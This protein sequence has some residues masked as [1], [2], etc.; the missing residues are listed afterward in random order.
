VRAPR[1]KA[2]KAQEPR[3]TRR[4]EDIIGSGPRGTRQERWPFKPQTVL[5]RLQGLRGGEWILALARHMLFFR[6]PSGTR[7]RIRTSAVAV[8]NAENDQTMDCRPRGVIILPEALPYERLVSVK[9][10]GTS[11][12][13][14]CGAQ[15]PADADFC[16]V[17][18]LRGALDVGNETVELNVAS[19]LSLPALRF[20]HYEIVT[21]ADGTPLELG[22]GAMGVTYKA[23]D[24]NLQCAVAL[25][26][27]NA[28]FIGDESARRRFVREARAAASVRHPNVASVFHLG[29]SADGYFYAMEFVEGE[30]LENVIKRTVQLELKLALEI[31][32]QVARGLAAVHKAK[33]VHRDIKPSNIM[34]SLDEGGS[35]TAKI[36]DL[37]LAKVVGEA[38]PESAI[39]ASGAFAGTPEFA[40]P[41]Q[42]AGVGVDIRSDL[43][44]LGVVIW[45]M[46]TGR[47]PFRGTPAELI[48]QHQH[49]VLPLK[50]LKGVP[51]QVTTVLKALLDKDPKRRFQTPAELLK[52][53]SMVG[54]ELVKAADQNH[55]VQEPL[56]QKSRVIAEQPRPGPV[57]GE[58]LIDVSSN[59]SGFLRDPKR[60]Y[61]QSPQDISVTPELVRK[62]ALRDGLWIKGEIR[63]V[64][65]GCQLSRLTE[66]NGEHPD[67][68][69]NL[70]VFEELTSLNPKSRIRLETVPDRY[71][72]RVMD[73]MT[74]VGKGQ[75]GLI[76]APPR[77]GKTTLLQHI[78]NAVVRNHPEVNL[79]IL[80]VDERREEVTEMRRT[81][82]Q[83]D[84]MASSNDSDFKTHT[85]IAELAIERAKRSVEAG[86]DVFL[87]MDSLTRIGRAFNNGMSTS[88]RPMSDGMAAQAMEM[89]RKLFAAARNTEEAGSLTIM[90][91]V[92]LETASKMDELIFQEFKGTGNVEI[93]LDRQISDQRVYPAIDI[94]KS[95]TR[96]EEL[97]I[98]ANDLEKINTIRRGL[99]GRRPVEAIERLLSFLR[100]FPTNAQVLRETGS[101]RAKSQ[102]RSVAVLP[103]ESLSAS[104]KDTYFADGVQDEILSNLAKVSE[105][106]VISRTS[107][108][109]FRPGDNRNLRS[110][111][112]S[113]G[114]ANVV[115][116]TVRRD[117]KHVRLTIRLVGAR[118]DKTLWSEIYDRDLIDVFA[119]QSEIAQT[120]ATKLSARLSPEER[121]AIEAKPTDD[122]EAYDLY[123]QAKQLVTDTP[124]VRL[125]D[126][127]ENLANA[128]N[129]L[130]AA[131]LKDSKFV[132]AYCLLV[133]AYDQLYRLDLADGRR[134]LGDAALK[135]AVRLQPELPDVHIASAFH[136]YRCYR[137]YAR[138][139]LQIAMA[140][141]SRPNSTDA[142][143]IAAYIDRE[144]GRLQESTRC[145]EQAIDLDPR[146]SEYLRQLATNYVCLN[147]IQQFER[148]YE[149]VIRI[150][151]EER[152]FLFLERAFFRLTAKADLTSCSEALAELPASLRNDRRIVSQQFAYALQARDWNMAKEIL[153]NNS[154][155]DLYFSEAEALVPC[156]SLWIWLARVQGD[157]SRT[158]ADFAAGRA[159]L[160]QRTKE[161]P[162]DPALLSALGLIDAALGQKKDAI[163]EA[164]CAVEMLPISSDAWYG[165]TLVYN[166]AA[167]YAL[168]NEPNQAIEQLTILAEVQGGIA[169]G[170]LK[171]DPAWDPLREDPRF[172][173]LITRLAP[174]D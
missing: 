40:S 68:Y 63:R 156:H 34:V 72:T 122:L 28:R 76:V 98:P 168:V 37:G 46:L 71:T 13:Q 146:N 83:A 127:Y 126:E 36:I 5:L 166:L 136:L 82:P 30:T 115:E 29:K 2:W 51:P 18:A 138:A 15:V 125:L 7:P 112:E 19:A 85:R 147:R 94:F 140:R 150:S 8:E 106:T 54:S 38:A 148:I 135:Q 123:L 69:R 41:E 16:P 26:V 14:A 132:L 142:F 50:Q 10:E 20:D 153:S 77:S 81:V 33:L 39:S 109:A 152:S 107:V 120:V 53:L 100:K 80:L 89:L 103:F 162:K 145:L 49:G 104:K 130:Q 131:V 95:G 170:E 105:L 60:N 141:R 93:V 21:R 74:P 42:F 45:E 48:Y 9:A 108:M 1:E 173:Q 124:G 87:L 113:L 65:R 44:S 35:L 12:C 165:P 24:I 78:A 121:K 129:L 158:K 4:V 174:R 144:Q 149:R 97:L 79:I 3:G 114:V 88:G 66:I 171:L 86:K 17:C 117:G 160:F 155:A 52:T 47:P 62:H 90:A 6:T 73:L 58:G 25:K 22:H 91:T 143:V 169:Y 164:K 75:R 96:R 92:L 172:E 59:G 11:T 55:D 161:Q 102:E 154:N 84:I 137:N 56:A 43:Y 101:G 139:R 134:V 133:K 116:G 31:A 163:E 110:I 167:A 159:A 128:V 99:A 27:I 32:V 67:R 111:A 61:V 151:P 57:Y 118:T 119:I 23:I 157:S 70:P 64:S